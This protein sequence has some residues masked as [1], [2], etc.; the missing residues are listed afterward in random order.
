MA[1]GEKGATAMLE[2]R[3][4]QPTALPSLSNEVVVREGDPVD[5]RSEICWGTPMHLPVDK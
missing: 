2:L 1:S 3:K 5:S 4:C